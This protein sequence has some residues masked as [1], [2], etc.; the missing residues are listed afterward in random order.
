MTEIREILLRVKRKESLRSISKTLCIHRKTINKYLSL[1]LDLGVDPTEDAITDE[2]T[3]KIKSRLAP[4]SKSSHI[5]R[6]DILLPH[7][8]RIEDYL[9]KGIKGSKI[10]TLLKRDGIVV[11]DSSFYRFINKRCENYIR[12]NITVR[13]P[14]TEP[15]KYLQADFGY[16]GLIWD[17][18]S[19]RLRKTHALIL[20]L[21]HSRHMYV[22]LT[23]KQD[24]RAVIEGFE[25]AWGYFEGITIIVIIDNLKPAI[26]KSDRYS[27]KINRQFLEYAQERGFIVDPANSGH[28]KGKPIVE[29]EV[30]YLRDNFFKGENFISIGDGRERALDWCSNVAGTRIHGTTRKVPCPGI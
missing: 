18:E 26:Y 28:P 30:P 24:I 17:E 23:F 7:K 27:P 11:G 1:C 6:D 2:L 5:P 9:E 20:T 4:G 3:E 14:E 12:K 25:A 22:Y 19:D 13:L 10:L 16:M 8:D 29:R 15:G 21:C